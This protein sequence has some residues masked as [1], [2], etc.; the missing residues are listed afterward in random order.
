MFKCGVHA[1]DIHRVAVG[2]RSGMTYVTCKTR[3]FD[4]H[5]LQKH[6]LRRW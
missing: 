4:V 3:A 2:G 1:D 5:M 6:Q